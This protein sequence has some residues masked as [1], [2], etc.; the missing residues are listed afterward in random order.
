M[1]W[2]C[3]K[4]LT[5]KLGKWRFLPVILLLAVFGMGCTQEPTSNSPMTVLTEHEPLVIDHNSSRVGSATTNCDADLAV[6]LAKHNV[7]VK[8]NWTNT[9]VFKIRTNVG[10]W[11]VILQ[12]KP[13]RVG[14]FWYV[15]IDHQGRVVSYQGGM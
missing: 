14:G 11:T 13:P 8:D 1:N 6:A 9:S 3:V 4:S 12:R 10:D 5:A 15:T 7:A 2:E